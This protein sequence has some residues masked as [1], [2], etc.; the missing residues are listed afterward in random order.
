MNA[1]ILLTGTIDPQNMVFTKLN[2]PEIRKSQY[3]KSIKFWLQNFDLPVVFVE[4]SGNDLSAYFEEELYSGKLEMLSFYGNNFDKTLGKGF[5]EMSCLEYALVK[6]K[7][8]KSNSLIFKITGR[9]KVLNFPNFYNF[10]R[11]A[12]ELQLLL[13]FKYNLSFCD[14]RIF[15]FTPDFFFKYLSPYK[16][17]INDT[18]GIFFEHILARAALNAIADN[19]I[20]YPFPSS[21]RIEGISGTFDQKYMSNFFMDLK[22]R[23]RYR[24]KFSIFRK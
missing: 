23:A 10:I 7:S 15:G 5:G 6:S 3:L 4:N 9:F 20:F 12:P 11:N 24:M 19:Y 8:I 16:E 2:D 22:A 21:P 18:N 14:S 13:D 1:V 17:I